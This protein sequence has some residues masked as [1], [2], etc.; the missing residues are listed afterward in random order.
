MTVKELQETLELTDSTIYLLRDRII[1]LLSELDG[2]YVDRYD[3]EKQL[4]AAGN[5]PDLAF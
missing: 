3:I 5:P 4:I 2:L 1:E